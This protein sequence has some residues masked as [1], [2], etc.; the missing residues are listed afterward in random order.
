MLITLVVLV[1]LLAFANGSNDNG[2]G[3]ATLVGFGAAKPLP[4]LV[5]ATAAT[6]LGGAVSFFFAGGL[7][8][9]FSGGW[10]FDKGVVLDQSFYAAVLIG[11]CGW[12]L[13]ANKTGMP[14]STTHAIIG[15]LCGAG[16]VAFGGAKFQWSMLGQK[17]AVPLAV[18]PVLSLAVRVRRW[19]GRCCSSS[20]GGA[21]GASAWWSASRLRRRPARCRDGRRRR[22][23]RWLRRVR[24]L[25]PRIGPQLAVV[26][27]REAE[28][29]AG[30]RGQPMAAASASG[31]RQ[32]RPLAERRADL[33]RP[34]LERHAE[35][36]RPEP[37]SPL[38]RRPRNGTRASP[39]VTNRHGGGGAAHGPARS[40]RRWRRS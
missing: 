6:A 5:Y 1:A 37:A 39:I 13:L 22:C 26:A 10:L 38:G 19:R 7:L 40:W 24:G 11:A 9:G 28:C 20:A 3:V 14:V 16:L 29:A 36:R 34:R 8:K 30:E 35:D 25:R 33:L 27:G 4:A 21:G 2:K 17:F 15:A 32:R 18:S 12:V 23:R 31:S